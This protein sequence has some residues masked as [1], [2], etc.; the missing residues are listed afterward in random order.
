MLPTNGM[1]PTNWTS[2]SHAHVR[3]AKLRDALATAS[4]DMLVGAAAGDGLLLNISDVC[5]IFEAALGVGGLGSALALLDTG[6]YHTSLVSALKRSG[7]RVHVSPAPIPGL[8]LRHVFLSFGHAVF[9]YVALKRQPG[10]AGYGACSPLRPGAF[11]MSALGRAE[12]GALC[13]SPPFAPQVT[14]VA[15][16]LSGANHSYHLFNGTPQPG[17]VAASSAHAV[18]GHAVT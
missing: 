16:C 17:V 9:Y 2:A 4:V 7:H 12:V 3:V 6:A 13:E 8:G 11:V 15:D 14:L 18:H 10:L 5:A 1:L